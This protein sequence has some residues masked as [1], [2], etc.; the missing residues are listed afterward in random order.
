[1]IAPPTP[2]PATGATDTVW[3]TVNK[4]LASNCRLRYD[5]A[6]AGEGLNVW[7][8]ADILPWDAWLDRLYLQLLDN[9]DTDLD[10]LTA[11]QERLL[12]Q[13]VIE[14]DDDTGKLLRPAAAAQMAQSSARLLADWQLQ[15]FPLDTLGGDETRT[16]LRWQRAFEATLAASGQITRAQLQP[17]LTSAFADGLLPPPGRVMRSGFDALSPVQRALFDE[18]ARLGCEIVDDTDEGAAARGQRVEAVDREHEITLAA[19]WANQRLHA[20]PTQRIGIVVPQITQHRA[21]LARIFAERTAP[22]YY[23]QQRT[24]Q[25][26]FNL[27]LGRALAD[28]ALAA[29]G[30]DLL[31][32]TVGGIALARLG[33]ILRSPFVGGHRDEWDARARLDAALRE[34]GMPSL[35]IRDLQSWL[36]RFAV[37]DP[38]RC[39]DLARRVDDIVARIAALPAR[40][41]PH[42][43][44]GHLQHLLAAFGWPGDAALDS[45]EYQAHERVRR[46]FS[47]F[48][49]LGKVQAELRHRD[50]VGLLRKLAVDTVFQPETEAAPIQILGPLEAV[51]M[52]FDAIWLLGV[53]DQTWPPQPQPD[54]LLPAALQRE[55]GMP[56]AAAERELAFARAL[57]ERLSRNCTVL[58]ASHARSDDGREQRPSALVRG[59]Q[60]VDAAAFAPAVQGGARAFAGKAAACE[61]LPRPVGTPL[62]TGAPGGSGLLGA[63]AV[64]PFQAVAR[65]RLDAVPLGEASHAPD[66]ADNGTMIHDLLQRVWQRL[67]GS[68]ALDDVSDDRLPALIEP[69]AAAVVGDAARRRPDLF[70]ARFRAIEAERLTRLVSDWLRVERGR[71]QG[72]VIEALERKQRLSLAGLQ[73]ETRIDRIDRLADGSIAVIDYKTGR[74]VGIDGWFD[75]RPN[76]PQLPLYCLQQDD[77]V[78]AVLLARVRHDDK[79]CAFVGLGRDAA[80]APGVGAAGEGG[81]PEW[82]PLLTHWRSALE[83]LAREIVDGRADPTPSLRACEYCTFGALCRVRGQEIEVDDD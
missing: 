6:R 20:D 41:T 30:L 11:T 66:A 8:S 68:V 42:I 74:T 52:R 77:E 35:A 73:L 83:D 39:D 60:L 34:H 36:Q 26:R 82:Q 5:A 15:R 65:F 49:A 32:L 38:R 78:S 72:F 57:T 53:D 7:P 21:D 45:A 63:Q 33:Q 9:G 44:A 79:G 71:E 17:M 25:A 50:A 29:A 10:L 27:S 56:H 22:D 16:L 13:Q 58:V 24:T 70:G 18:L 2:I 69:L 55:L 51:G 75:P 40:A 12:W 76:E 54:P 4:R 23:L 62:L 37:D 19:E 48:A 28:T 31:E 14:R 1:M 67:G 61:A 46:L 43:W 80:F 47:E 81:L 64:C 3:L 59:W